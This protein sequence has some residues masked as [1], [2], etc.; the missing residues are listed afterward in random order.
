[1]NDRD[2]IKS[3]DKAVNLILLI[4]Q[5]DSPIKLER[6]VKISG[7]K[8]TSCFRILQTLAKSGFVARDGD[9]NGFLIGPKFISIGLSAF[10]RRG[11]R[12]LALPVM[13]QVQRNTGTTVNL[14]ILSGLEVIF[15]ERL[16]SAHII[17][18]NLRVGSRLSVHV[19]SMGK[20][21]LAY[22]PDSELDAILEQLHF[23]KK[24]EKTITSIKAFKQELQ[25]IRQ[26]GFAINN[27][28][29][30]KGLFA[31]AAPVRNYT[32]A[33]IASLNVSF[34]LVRHSRQEAIAKF[35]PI[36]LDACRK[37]SLSLGFQEK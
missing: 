17:D 2:Y 9:S 8:K 16:Q 15:I 23:E 13:K 19:S 37:I 35:R 22:L 32:G 25:D 5:Q 10:D 29:L 31:I 33:A 12:E 36:L 1:M 4:S 28:E 27:E 6:L 24:T 18:A 14:A 3:L 20:A 26:R 30:E 11:L 21:I 34:P 7:I